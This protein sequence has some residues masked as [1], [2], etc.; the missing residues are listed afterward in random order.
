MKP[1]KN[2]FHRL[3]RSIFKR[4]YTSHSVASKEI[5]W[6]PAGLMRWLLWREMLNLISSLL[7]K[8]CS[9]K[10]GRNCLLFRR[11]MSFD[12]I[13]VSAASVAGSTW[14]GPGACAAGWIKLWVVWACDAGVVI[15]TKSARESRLIFGA[16]KKWKKIVFCACAQK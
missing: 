10:R 6:K 2:Y 4:L 1:P 3:S 13:Q 11:R 7:K 5:T 9:L 16:L 12:P 8:A 14:I 15:P